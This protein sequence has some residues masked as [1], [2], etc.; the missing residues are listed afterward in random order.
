[1]TLIFIVSA[2]ILLLGVVLFVRAIRGRQI[3]SNQHCRACKFDLVGLGLNRD[4]LCPECGKPI[5]PNTPTIQVG[6]RKRR[7]VFATLAVLLILLGGVGIAW[8]KVSQLPTIKNIDWYAKFPESMLLKLEAGGDKQALQTLH[9]R[10]IPGTLSDQALQSLITRS[11]ILIDDET[12][13]WDKRWGD[14]ILYAFIMEK[15][16]DEHLFQVMERSYQ[17]RAS[18]HDEIDMDTEQV[19][20]WL[21]ID[22]PPNGK[23][24]PNFEMKLAQALV[25]GVT[26]PDL[27]TPYQLRIETRLPH[28]PGPRE[29]RGGYGAIGVHDPDKPGWW[30]PFPY[31]GHGM[32]G[33]MR[34]PKETEEFEAHFEAHYLMYKDDRLFHEWSESIVKHVRRV[35]NPEYLERVK[36]SP[37][38]EALV[39]TITMRSISVPTQ[40]DEAR[41]HDRIMNGSPGITAVITSV[42]SDMGLLGE[43]WFDNG[44]STLLFAPIKLEETKENHHYSLSAPHEYDKKGQSWIDWFDR[45][46]QFWE[47]A[48]ENNSV[49]V[50]YKPMHTMAASHPQLKK[51]IDEPIVFKD[52]PINIQVPQQRDVHIGRNGPIEEH[53]GMENKN[54]PEVGVRYSSEEYKRLFGRGDPAHGELITDSEEESP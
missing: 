11:L 5:I 12:I 17:S 21:N 46:K 2:C 10:L 40:L 32:G 54:Q 44:E 28:K 16:T 18:I 27:P 25:P 47:V 39:G 31:S 52:V 8:P 14:V 20:V 22:S 35:P 41:Q 50:I 24:D 42:A 1:M 6:L 13:V 26:F 48:A 49:N 3:S 9:D 19:A 15:L 7:P 23:S 33:Q 53:W 45:N 34:V 51:M 30:L 29:R 38:L 4:S 37:E 43:L 36:R